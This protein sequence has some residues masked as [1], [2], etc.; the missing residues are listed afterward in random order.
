MA[1]LPVWPHR[2]LA[3]KMDARAGHV[4]PL[5]VGCDLVADEIDHLGAAVALRHRQRPARD[6]PDMLLELR[7]RTSVERPVARVVHAWRDL[8]HHYG[9]S[10]PI[11][12]DQP[13]HPT[14]PHI[15]ECSA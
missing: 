13:P 10:G 14:P 8:V 1:H 6:G 7:H 5:T 4:Q 15:T 2:L 9:M 3:V 11:A 12:N